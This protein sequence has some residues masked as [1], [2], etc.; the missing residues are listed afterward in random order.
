M[1]GSALSESTIAPSDA[2]TRF[3]RWALALGLGLRLV[4]LWQTSALGTHIIDEQHYRTI[5]EN[6]LAGHGF[7]WGPGALTSIRPPL[8]PGL[9]A[10]VWG[11]FGAGNLQA[12]RV[13]QIAMA[14]ALSAVV[15]ALGARVYN[16]PVGRVA[17]GIVWLY[18]SF[19]FF[20]FLILTETLFTLLL[21]GFVLSCVALVQTPRARTAL[22][23]GIVLGLSALTR[24]V[25]WPAPLLLCP[26]MALL[27]P[28]PWLRRLALPAVLLAGYCL[29]VGPWALRN[30]RLQEVF[31]V[32]DTMGGINLR[33]G[34]YEFTPDDRM[35]DTVSISGDRSWVHGF[36]VDSPELAPTEGRKDKWAQREAVKYM[37]AHPA[38]TV[39]R[40]LIKF[41]DFWGLEREF[42]AGVEVGFFSP[43]RWFAWTGALL[44]VGTFVIL[45]LAGGAGLWL[46]APDDWRLQVLLLFP[47]A[48]IVGGHTIVFGHSRYHLPLVPLLALY[49]TQ[50]AFQ[51]PKV[52]ASALPMRVAAMATVAIL[53]IIWVRQVVLV[54]AARIAA[55]F[56]RMG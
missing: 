43:P 22:V 44:M 37:A 55:L 47:I 27:I 30:T 50:L 54:D 34:N 31:T 33:M 16:R 12:V 24:S 45:A 40:S 4:V 26:L 7:G 9:L 11:L 25:L 3:L 5:A 41:A 36:T 46:A 23:C 8:Y 29:V 32:V 10:A 51:F 13:L 42:I 52:R 20:N 49:A 53:L 19:I 56:Q 48:L 39:R 2:G 35:W 14:L 1:P 15:Y 18:P 17:A 6:M 28:G 38:Q 21:L